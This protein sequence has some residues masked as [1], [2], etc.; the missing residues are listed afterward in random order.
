MNGRL[1]RC[2]VV[3]RGRVQGVG[4]RV[5][6]ARQARAAGVPALEIGRTSGNALT[7]GPGNTIS[8]AKLATAHEGF[9]PGLMGG[10]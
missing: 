1:L 3:I 8:L 5:S 2:R 9:L 7:V 6:C 10:A 4:F